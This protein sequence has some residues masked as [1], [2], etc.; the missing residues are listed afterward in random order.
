LKTEEIVDKIALCARTLIELSDLSVPLSVHQLEDFKEKIHWL[1][2]TFVINYAK[3]LF[4]KES[5]KSIE[6]QKL[7]EDA[8]VLNSLGNTFIKFQ[9]KM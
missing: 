9:E 7:E 8:R 2:S 1:C 3:T 5:E 6:I 4:A